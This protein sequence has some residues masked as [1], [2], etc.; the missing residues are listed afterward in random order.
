MA[1]GFAVAACANRCRTGRTRSSACTSWRAIPGPSIGSTGGCGGRTSARRHRRRTRSPRSESLTN[2][3]RPS[4][5]RSHVG[6]V[7][8]GPGQHWRRWQS[9]LEFRAP[10]RSHGC[11]VATANAPQRRRGNDAG[12][13]RS[14]PLSDVARPPRALLSIAFTEHVDAEDEHC[15]VL[16]ALARSDRAPGSRHPPADAAR[17][18]RLVV[19][20]R[21]QSGLLRQRRPPTVPRGPRLPGRRRDGRGS[22]VP[23]GSRSLDF[24]RRKP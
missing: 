16:R 24:W 4:G 19:P 14:K 6:A 1:A 10:R 21:W 11:E 5:S 20:S 9:S 17:D 13:S 18:R 12:S 15:A 2:A 3:A 23:A 22:R 7:S 8:A